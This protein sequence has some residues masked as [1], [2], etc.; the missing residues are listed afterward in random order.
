MPSGWMFY[1]LWEARKF[2]DTIIVG[3]CLSATETLPQNMHPKH[4]T[5]NLC[6]HS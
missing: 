2:I 5:D 6:E 1:S 4:S 3:E